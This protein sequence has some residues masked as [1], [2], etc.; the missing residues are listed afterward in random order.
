M[1]INIYMNINDFQNAVIYKDVGMVTGA[2][3]KH[4]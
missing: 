2:C 3:H 1:T 4:W